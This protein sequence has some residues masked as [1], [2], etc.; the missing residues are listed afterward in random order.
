MIPPTTEGKKRLFCEILVRYMRRGYLSDEYDDDVMKGMLGSGHIRG[1]NDP[2]TSTETIETTEAGRRY[3]WSAGRS[4]PGVYDD[5][6]LMGMA[7]CGYIEWVT[8]MITNVQTITTTG[9]GRACLIYYGC[10]FSWIKH[11]VRY[12]LKGG[13]VRQ[14]IIEQ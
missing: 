14:V 12:G 8:N 3:M 2:W 11:L 9:V 4:F 1:W 13:A 10:N 7:N 5:W 6:F